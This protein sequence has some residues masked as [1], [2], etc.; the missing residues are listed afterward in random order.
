MAHGDAREEN[1]R[2]N[3]RMEWVTSTLYT[4]SEH[5]LFNITTADAD[6]S[7]VSSRLNW[8]PPPHPRR[9]KWTRPFRRKTKSGFCACAITFQLAS[10]STRDFR[11]RCSVV[12][13]LHSSG[14]WCSVCCS[15]VLHLPSLQELISLGLAEPKVLAITIDIRCR[16]SQKEVLLTPIRQARELISGPCLSAQARFL[17]F[18]RTQPR[19][20]TGLLTGHNTL[21][22]HLHLIELSIHCV[23]DV[24]QRKKPRPTLCMNG[25]LWLQT[26]LFIWAPSSWSRM[27]SG[28]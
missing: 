21:R 6:T 7:A 23:G 5:G 16:T 1:W 9:F 14:M 22:R 19:A 18:N 24:E 17:S 10:A 26:D 2:V 8:R 3:W 27:T 15:D 11:P 13:G 25:K 12:W 4:T 20:V 28:V